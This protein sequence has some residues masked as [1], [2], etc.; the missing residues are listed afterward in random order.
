[1]QKWLAHPDATDTKIV[2][3]LSHAQRVLAPSSVLQGRCLICPASLQDSRIGASS[4]EFVEGSGPQRDS[5]RAFAG[6]QGHSAGA[7]QHSV[8]P[9]RKR[10]LFESGMAAENSK[11]NEQSGDVRKSGR[12]AALILGE[13]SPKQEIA[14]NL[15]EHSA[16][17]KSQYF[18]DELKC[19]VVVS[20]RD[21]R[22]KVIH[23]QGT[24][25]TA[26]VVV[27]SGAVFFSGEVFRPT[28]T[29]QRNAAAN[30]ALAKLAALART[31]L[32]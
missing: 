13:T 10:H 12:R 18:V 3:C 2:D 8:F 7:D 24:Q 9:S 6:A 31:W 23:L 5:L 4:P 26:A 22:Q 32:H 20:E 27:P 17:Y 30:A 29:T 16:P 28:A 11:T 1:M 15:G 25:D 19:R 21:G 14:S